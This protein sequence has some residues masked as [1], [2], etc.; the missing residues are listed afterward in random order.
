MVK[1]TLEIDGMAC[2]MCETHVNDAVRKAFVVKKLPYS[3]NVVRE[4]FQ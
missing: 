1:T 4:L 2:G 3:I